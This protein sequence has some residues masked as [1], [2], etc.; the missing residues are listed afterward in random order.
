[1]QDSFDVFALVVGG[2]DYK[3]GQFETG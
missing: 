1:M 2:Y 3:I